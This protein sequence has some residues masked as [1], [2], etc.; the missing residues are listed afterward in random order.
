MT[1]AHPAR[2]LASLGVATLLLTASD[3][4]SSAAERDRGP[5][6]A[7]KRGGAGLR[8]LLFCEEGLAVIKEGDDRYRRSGLYWDHQ[9][10]GGHRYRPP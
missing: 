7:L 10:F 9:E 2:C 3:A 4:P 5:A 1:R 6:V 8:L